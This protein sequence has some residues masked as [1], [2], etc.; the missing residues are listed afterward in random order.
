MDQ[1]TSKPI[2]SLPKVATELNSAISSDTIQL[3]CLYTLCLFVPVVY[4]VYQSGHSGPT[5]KQQWF[6]QE[7]VKKLLISNVVAHFCI[8][9]VD[10]GGHPCPISSK[11]SL[12]KHSW[13]LAPAGGA[14]GS[15]KH[16]N[17]LTNGL[18]TI[19]NKTAKATIPTIS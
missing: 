8:G 3:Y 10:R 11:I 14:G 9:C 12:S 2:Q 15:H 16:C 1:V 6:G 13:C 7:A 18:C 5:S 19:K 17:K 4:W